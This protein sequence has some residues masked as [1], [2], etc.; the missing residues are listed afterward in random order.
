MQNFGSGNQQGSRNSQGLKRQQGSRRQQGLGQQGFGQQAPS[1]QAIGEQLSEQL[2]SM[3][4]AASQYVINP[5]AKAAKGFINQVTTPASKRVELARD[6]GRP[7]ADYFINAL[8]TQFMEMHGD[9]L[10]KDDNSIKGG[11]AYF[12]D[13]PVTVIAQCKGKNLEDNL[14]YNFG[15]PNPQGYRK[16]MRLAKQA[17]K[18]GRPIITIID[19]PGAYPGVEAEEKGQGEAIARSIALFSSL[20]VPVIA[21][22]IGEGGSG[23]ALAL[24]VANSIIMLENA[25]YSILSPEGFAAILWKDASRSKEAASV[26]KLTSYDIASFGI[27]DAVIPEGEPPLQMPC[28]DVVER[29]DSVLVSEILRLA[30]KDGEVLAQE[31]YEKFRKIGKCIEM[32]GE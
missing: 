16:A 24:G 31:R 17:E 22:F 25:I 26:M 28:D 3:Q 10:D 11:I 7:N 5:L 12:H 9:R 27:A 32:K 4:Q 2:S 30:P 19:T 8:F 6:P 1:A 23:G 29:I 20:K 14:K 13:L 21:L 15:M 18:F